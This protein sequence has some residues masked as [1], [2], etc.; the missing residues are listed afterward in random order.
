MKVRLYR[1]RL[2]SQGYD[3]R[4]RYFG[5]GLPLYYYFYDYEV[6]GE[7]KDGDGYFRASSREKAKQMV[8]TCVPDAK[9]Y[10]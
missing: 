9:F 2:N 1:V 10:R 6:D 4:G 5:V 8:A 7:Y 3:N